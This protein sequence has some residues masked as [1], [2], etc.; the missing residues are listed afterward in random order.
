MH[1]KTYAECMDMHKRKIKYKNKIKN[2]A[3][4][5]LSETCLLHISDDK[6]SRVWLKG[7]KESNTLTTEIR[8]K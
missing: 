7:T 1:P 6:P 2:P 4:L 8:I 3:A 5:C